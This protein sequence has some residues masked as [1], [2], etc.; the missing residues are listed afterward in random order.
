MIQLYADGVLAY[1]SRLKEHGKDH[2]LLGLKTTTGLNKGGTAEFIMPPGHPAYDLFV[3][4]RT[5]V[6]LYRDNV[7]KFRGRVLYPADNFNN[8][9]TITCEGELCLFQDGIS[10][11]YLYQDTPAAIF[12]AVVGDYNAQVEEYKRFRVGEITVTD[13]NNY[14][15]LE[16]ENTETVLDTI[17]K[18]LE[19]CGGYIVFTT[20]EDGVR[21]VN[22]YAELEHRSS[23][24]IEFGANLLDFSRTGANTALATGIRPEGAK[25][26]ATGKRITIESV[27]GGLDYIVD[28]AA[29][30]LRGTIIKAVQWDDVT[31]PSIL[32]TKAQQYLREARQIVTSL[33]LSAVDLSYLDKDIESYKVGDSV[34]VLS[35]PHAVDEYF[36]LTERT[37]DYLNPAQSSITLG[38]DLRTLTDA[39]VAG[40]KQSQSDLYKVTLSVRADY[41]KDIEQAVKEAEKTMASLIEQDEGNILLKVSEEYATKAALQRTD[42]ELA[43]TGAE[44]RNHTSQIEKVQT[45][46]TTMQLTTEGVSIKVQD[47]IDN[48]V[49]R[50]KTGMGYTFD[51]EGLCI[52]K[53]GQEIQNLLD[54]RGV[55]VT[56]DGEIML[57]ADASGVIAADVKVRNYLIVGEH[58]RFEDYSNGTDSRRTACFWLG[59]G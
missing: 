35:R 36:Q 46:L 2:T 12:A 4:F 28:E 53:E 29:V 3:S 38:K 24:A 55:H 15:R 27:N 32:L 16:S 34:R 43:S 42:T 17:N 23:Q 21:V 57:Q 54:H 41:A 25:D 37:E 50:V 48:G 49:S 5:I 45:D 40:D 39:D 44:V 30:A 51:D 20:A 9:R 26:Q 52:K 18:L 14:V 6:E 13:A 7:L 33:K 19:R 59:G 1:D 10:R 47:I 31:T 11:P 8:L 58:A 22:W 56:R